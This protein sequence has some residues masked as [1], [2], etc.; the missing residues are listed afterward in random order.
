MKRMKFEKPTL[1][2]IAFSDS[3]IMTVSDCLFDIS[4]EGNDSP[5][6]DSGVDYGVPE[7]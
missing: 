6:G 1:E 7:Y 5:G 2:R 4:L 3:D